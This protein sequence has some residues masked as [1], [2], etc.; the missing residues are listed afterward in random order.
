MNILSLKLHNFLSHKDTEFNFTKSDIYNILGH[1]GAGKSSISDS[2]T[3]CLFGK[4]RVSGNG[5][6]LIHNTEK[7]ISVTVEL[8]SNSIKYKITRFKERNQPTKLTVE[9]V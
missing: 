3:W 4:S 2:I 9:E 8:E 7:E 1:N 5:D 6:E